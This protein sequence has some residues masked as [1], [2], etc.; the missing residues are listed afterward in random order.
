MYSYEPKAKL[1]GLPKDDKLIG[2]SVYKYSYE[3]QKKN[4]TWNHVGHVYNHFGGGPRRPLLVVWLWNEDYVV[5]I[6]DLFWNP[7]MKYM[8]FKECYGNLVRKMHE[9]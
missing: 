6:K 9:I 4:W 2:S 7:M 3:I 8:K 5:R 1:Y